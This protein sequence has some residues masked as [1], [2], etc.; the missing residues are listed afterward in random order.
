VVDPGARSCPQCGHAQAGGEFCEVCGTRLAAAAAAGFPPAGGA[1]GA[2]PPPPVSGPGAATPPPYAAQPQPVYGGYPAGGQE[3]GFFAKLFDFSF[4]NFITPTIIKALFIIYIVVVAL[5]SL[6][7][8]IVAFTQSAL[9]GILTLI[10]GVPIFGFIYILVGRVWLELVI[11][12][13]RIHENTEA[14][15]V[16]KRAGR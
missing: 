2:A 3:P 4:E 1:G 9:V 10:V 8:V 14:L 12:F 13:F 7:M 11:I 5:I 6:A 16:Q 15:A